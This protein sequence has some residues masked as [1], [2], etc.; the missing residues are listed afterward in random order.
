MPMQKIRI[1]QVTRVERSIVIDV[2][3]ATMDE[4]VEKQSESEAPGHDDPRWTVDRDSLENE[5]VEP[6]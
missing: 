5:T 6:A 2:E 1:T 4:A 3:A